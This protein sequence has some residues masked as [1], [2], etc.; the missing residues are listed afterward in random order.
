MKKKQNKIIGFFKNL[1][2]RMLKHDLATMSAAMSYYYLSVSIPLMLVLTALVGEFLGGNRKLLL[3]L[4]E[5]LP[6]TTKELVVSMIDSLLNS[7]NKSSLSIITL[8]FAVWSASN[9]IFNLLD[10]LN[11][12]YGTKN[13]K[14]SILK[15]VLSFLYTFVLIIIVIVFMSIRIYG[16]KIIEMINNF[17]SKVG[18]EPFTEQI[19]Y[20]SSL[21]SNILPLI[22]MSMALALLY[23]IAANRDKDFNISYK[24]GLIGGIFTT[25]IILIGSFAY[26]YFLDNMSNM[27]V[28]YGALTGFL[29]LFV[30]IYIFS[31][32]IIL[33]AEVIAAYIEV[34]E[35][36]VRNI[37]KEIEDKL[38]DSMKE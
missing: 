34:K 9:G 33:G 36:C 35:G 8:I 18:L 17:L 12:A 1:I 31:Y 38:P 27:S 21:I 28:I 25:L 37:P 32:S 6:D 30:W 3:E 16:P 10:S 24:Q 15:K 2:N 14:S 13:I 22:V 20:I 19:T 5:I 29:S 11:K 7:Q 4:V 26:S 23:K